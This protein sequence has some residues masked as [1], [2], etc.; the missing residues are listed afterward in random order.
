MAI[1]WN[2]VPLHRS[3]AMFCCFVSQYFAFFVFVW[4]VVFGYGM[5]GTGV[6]CTKVQYIPCAATSPLSWRLSPRLSLPPIS[7]LHHLFYYHGFTKHSADPGN[8]ERFT[9]SL[10]HGC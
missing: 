2:G 1:R 8:A 4:L 10:Q 9:S 3:T 7:L 5:L 6:V